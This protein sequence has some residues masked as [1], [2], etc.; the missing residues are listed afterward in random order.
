MLKSVC[1]VKKSDVV[2]VMSGKER[3]KT[4]KVLKV[5]Q[6]RGRVFIEK[7]NMIKRHKKPVGQQAGGIIEAEGGISASSILLFCDKCGRGV[8]TKVKGLESGKKIRVC[9]KCNGELDK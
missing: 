2:Q 7:L 3:G 4:G 5:N 6:K 9:K 1:H 8:R